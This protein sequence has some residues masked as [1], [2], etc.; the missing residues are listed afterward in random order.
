MT[1]TTTVKLT[2]CQAKAIA[3]MKEFISMDCHET[4]FRL[5]GYAGTGKSFVICQLIKWLQE[6]E[7]NFLA[8]SP[9]NKAANNLRKIANENGIKIEAITLARLLKQQAVVDIKTGKEKFVTQN[10]IDLENYEVIIADEFSMISEN[11]FVDLAIEVQNFSVKVIF[12]GDA[13][14]LPP[15]GEKE[16]I[17]ATHKSITRHA[18]LE[19]VVRYDGELAKVAEKIRSKDFYNKIMYPFET[20]A[21][22]SILCLNRSKWLNQAVTLFKSDEFKANPNYVRFLVWRNKQADILNS[23]VRFYLWGG[24]APT[25]MPGDRLIAKVPVF[26]AIT[27]LSKGGKEL[28]K[29]STVMNSSDECVVIEEG[30]LIARD[31]SYGYECYCVPVLTDGGTK[32]DLFILTE[33]G[34]QQQKK[35]LTD[36]RAEA[37][38][39]KNVKARK[40]IWKAYY[41]CLK[42]FDTMPY[43]YAITTHKAQGSTIDC[44]FVDATDMRGCPDLQKIL[45]TALTR[46]KDRVFIPE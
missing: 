4:F 25:Y 31:R 38:E 32:L 26:R 36:L 5:T 8:C 34:K 37:N 19:T 33:E 14:Q 30:K 27:A 35:Y 2:E 23:Y 21:D 20:T 6:N 7:Y 11:N 12:V 18:N 45:Y 29:W 24:D 44:A 17:V 15:V 9:T 3:K 22:D 13:A 28:E 16:P 39:C 41:D 46:A 10:D 1:N 43:A 42:T 40:G